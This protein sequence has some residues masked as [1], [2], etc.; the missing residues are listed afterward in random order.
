MSFAITGF[1]GE[2]LRAQPQPFQ[3]LSLG[4]RPPVPPA[5]AYGTPNANLVPVRRPAAA[6]TNLT[7]AAQPTFQAILNLGTVAL[8]RPGITA[9]ANSTAAVSAFNPGV[10][11]QQLGPIGGPPI[12]NVPA[13]PVSFTL[14]V[15]PAV[16][17]RVSTLSPPTTPPTP[18]TQPTPT[19]HQTSS[20][21]ATRATVPPSNPS[22]VARISA[23]VRQIAVSAV[24]QAPGFSFSA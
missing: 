3:A 18:A 21:P 12:A 2:Q 22:V 8:A 5:P 23:T 10:Q 24:Y 19:A 13:G 1:A 20:T 7:L 15:A 4:G 6:T 17:T 9:P 14:T 11:H 16:I